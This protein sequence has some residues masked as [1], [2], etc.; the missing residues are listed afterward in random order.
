MNKIRTKEWQTVYTELQAISQLAFGWDGDRAP[1]ISPELLNSARELLEILEQDRP[2]APPSRIVPGVSGVVS[3][4]WRDGKNY[5]E[6][7]IIAPYK[8][9]IFFKL[10]DRPPESI[11]DFTWKPVVIQPQP[12]ISSVW[13]HEEYST[14]LTDHIANGASK[15]TWIRSE[16]IL[17]FEKSVHA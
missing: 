3:L 15:S 8:A 5:S 13:G 2:Y 6:L 4:E 10:E 11:D 12:I 9:E 7:E 14:Y 17:P 16:E 1:A